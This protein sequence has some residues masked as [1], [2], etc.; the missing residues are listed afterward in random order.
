[1]IT[2]VAVEGY[3]SLRE[4]VLPLG[5][6]TV[7]TGGNGS[8]KTN[9]YRAL[10]LLSGIAL[11]GAVGALARE[12]GLD[13]TLWAGP[14]GTGLEVRQGRAP[15]QGTRRRRPVALRLGVVAD[16]HGYAADLGLPQEGGV[17]ARDP[18]IKVEAV[19]TGEVLRAGSLVAERHGPTAR[20]RDDEGGWRRMPEQLAT[21]DSLLSEVVDPAG[22]PEL[23]AVRRTLRSWRFYD[24]FR[25]DPDAPARQERV[26]TRTPVLAADGGD[27]A[28]A[29]ATIVDAGWGDLLDEAVTAAFGDARVAVVERGGLLGLELHQHGLLRPLRGAEL[30]DG[31]LRYL[32]WAAALLS[33]RP[34]RLLVL[35]EPETSLHPDLLPGL[36][37]LV[38]AAAR[39]TQVVVVTHSAALRRVLADAEDLAEVELVKELGATRVRGQEGPFD[40][41]AWSWP[42][43]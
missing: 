30:S 13:S 6:L 2:T 21:G 37:G 23:S 8:G 1:M 27:L 22:A 15:V 20:L 11:G 3:R 25:A 33:P 16:G 17:F 14:E 24:G 39:R 28:A 32:L 7:V 10:R 26:G 31:T 9:L 4:L 12:G 36:G 35:N 18:E 38:A 5:Q 42:S 29:V 19:W 41:P 43:R 40:V 34:P